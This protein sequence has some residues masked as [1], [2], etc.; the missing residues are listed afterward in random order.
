MTCG[1]ILVSRYPLLTS[2]MRLPIPPQAHVDYQFKIT[3]KLAFHISALIRTLFGMRI[4][5]ADAYSYSETHLLSSIMES[6]AFFDR[7]SATGPLQLID[8]NWIFAYN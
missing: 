3:G 6:F 1:H 5:S 2:D 4:L 8:M 7:K